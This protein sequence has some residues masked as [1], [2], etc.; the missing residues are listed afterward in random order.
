MTLSE[1]DKDIALLG[2]PNTDM[3]SVFR[4]G[5]LAGIEAANFGENVIAP[6]W[7]QRDGAKLNRF[8]QGVEY[9]YAIHHKLMEKL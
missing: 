4:N 1:T 2:T 7:V 5:M 9:G 6:L 8:N 3:N